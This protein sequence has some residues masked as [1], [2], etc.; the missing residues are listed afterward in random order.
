[1]GVS[2]PVY[3]GVTGTSQ[4]LSVLFHSFLG[5]WDEW[6]RMGS[7]SYEGITG[8]P[9]GKRNWKQ[10]RRKDT[11]WTISFP[12]HWL[13]LESKFYTWCVYSFE[14]RLRGVVWNCT[15]LTKDLLGIDIPTLSSGL[16][17]TGYRCTQMI[18]ELYCYKI[19]IS[20]FDFYHSVIKG[21]KEKWKIT[22]RTFS[23]LIGV[24]NVI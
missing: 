6:F 22:W 14:K 8:P 20:V 23:I 18:Q 12:V 16:D 19:T 1:M 15:S 9:R 3:D 7:R 24:T 10:S 21:N 17:T 4:L 2:D 13:V 5:R 11:H